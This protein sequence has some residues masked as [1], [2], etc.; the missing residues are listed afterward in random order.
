MR[1]KRSAYCAGV[2]P[3]TCVGVLLSVASAGSVAWADG[4]VGAS[5]RVLLG[6]V[7]GMNSVGAGA[8]A[9]TWLGACAHAA[10]ASVMA[11]KT[12]VF[13]TKFLNLSRRANFDPREA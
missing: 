2:S 12:A 9:I 3:A 11:A 5:G 8:G 4:G 1:S 6:C 13:V 7:G 10:R